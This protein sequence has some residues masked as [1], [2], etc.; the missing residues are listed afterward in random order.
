MG[1]PLCT[2]TEEGQVFSA[3]N[4][5]AWKHCPAVKRPEGG[6]PKQW[7]AEKDLVGQ[8]LGGGCKDPMGVFFSFFFFFFSKTLLSFFF[9]AF[10]LS[11]LDFFL[12]SS[13][14]TWWIFFGMIHPA[15]EIS[16]VVFKN[17]LHEWMHSFSSK[18]FWCTAQGSSG[19]CLSFLEGKRGCAQWKR[20]QLEMRKVVYGSQKMS[21]RCL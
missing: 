13:S 1:R 9:S 15:G 12:S 14:R 4:N 19:K 11:F 16:S 21:Y 5:M 6:R 10:S 7:S 8:A 3:L 20:G 2:A 18:P 17:M